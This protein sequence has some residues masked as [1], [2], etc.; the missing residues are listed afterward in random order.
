MEA[1]PLLLIELKVDKG[2]ISI[3]AE[4]ISNAGLG[5]DVTGATGVGF[6]FAAQVADVD[7]QQVQVVCI[8]HAPYLA[9]CRFHKNQIMPPWLPNSDP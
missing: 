2:S 8:S 1:R 9:H 5:H 6:D 7:P 4:A 3:Q